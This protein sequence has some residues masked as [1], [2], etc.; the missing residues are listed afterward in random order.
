MIENIFTLDESPIYKEKYLIKIKI[1]SLPFPRGT[2]GS[3][4]IL[5]ARFLNLSYPDYLRYCRDRL[6]ADL[7][8]KNKKY[9][10]PYFD[11]TPEV[12]EF[13]RLLNNR[14]ALVKNEQEYPYEYS[15]GENGEITR[16]PFSEINE[17]N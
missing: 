15:I 6:G 16:T 4:N 17:S 8:G 12:R 1:D 2:T 14:Y 13:V 9:V 10:V 7:V 11:K 5:P 3:Y